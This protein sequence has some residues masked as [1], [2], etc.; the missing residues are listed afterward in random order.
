M[1]Y[2]L[3]FE[4]GLLTAGLLG[5]IWAAARAKKRWVRRTIA[6]LVAGGCAWGA[7]A[8]MM[9]SVNGYGGLLTN[10]PALF[11]QLADVFGTDPEAHHSLN[12]LVVEATIRFPAGAQG[13]REALVSSGG[14]HGGDWIL[15]EYLGNS[16]VRFGYDHSRRMVVWSKEMPIE[17]DKRYG[18]SV[19]YQPNAR[20]D[21]TLTVRVDGQTVL[22]VMGTPYSTNLKNVRVGEDSLR[23]GRLRSFSGELEMR[24]AM[25][26]GLGR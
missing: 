2:H 12:E 1:R 17:A 26:V 25:S 15:V 22:T 13:G 20:G 21:T 4:P 10:N 14:S 19:R 8:G 23:R 9:L 11:W 6:V 24:A 3:D 5:S 16:R 18:L 7:A